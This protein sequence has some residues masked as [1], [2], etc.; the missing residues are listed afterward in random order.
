MRQESPLRNSHINDVPFF[1][2]VRTIY[3]RRILVNIFEKK[4]VKM[5]VPWK[6][7]KE[8][9]ILFFYNNQ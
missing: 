3:L 6:V 4:T 5:F 7:L 8:L 9:K 1:T 2:V